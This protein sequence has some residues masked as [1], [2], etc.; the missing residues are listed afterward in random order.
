M[1]KEEVDSSYEIFID[2]I[3]EVD[4]NMLTPMQALTKLDEIINEAKDL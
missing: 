4:V 3:R 1:S 2:K